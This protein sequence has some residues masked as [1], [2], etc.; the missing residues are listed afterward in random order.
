MIEIVEDFRV[1]SGSLFSSFGGKVHFIAKEN[2]YRVC[3]SYWTEYCNT[4]D[5]ARRYISLLV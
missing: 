5:D 4:L 1:R 3:F 2:R